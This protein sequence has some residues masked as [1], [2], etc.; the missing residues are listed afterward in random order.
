MY[1]KRTQTETEKTRRRQI[2]E[3]GE[4][5]MGGRGEKGEQGR[6]KC[7]KHLTPPF[8]AIF[9]GALRCSSAPGSISARNLRE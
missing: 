8:R 2:R 3:R 1:G 7:K 6:A 5:R 4:G 9:L